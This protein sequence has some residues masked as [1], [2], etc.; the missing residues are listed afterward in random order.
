MHQRGGGEGGLSLPRGI[1]SDTCN[2]V[3]MP[4]G[5]CT[6]HIGNDEQD[7]GNPKCEQTCRNMFNYRQTESQMFTKFSA[8]YFSGIYRF[9]CHILH[10]FITSAC[11]SIA[12]SL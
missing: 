3:G 8:N 11:S 6:D 2:A 5:F 7:Q 4:I 1:I 10:V 12:L 9:I